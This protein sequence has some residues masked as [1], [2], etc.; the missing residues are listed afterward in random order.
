MN[1]SQLL[2]DRH[3]ARGPAEVLRW[4]TPEGGSTAA[5]G[6][7]EEIPISI[8][9]PPLIYFEIFWIILSSVQELFIALHTG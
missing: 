6:L 5:R 1:I 7:Y 2:E 3:S 4:G 8:H 9:I